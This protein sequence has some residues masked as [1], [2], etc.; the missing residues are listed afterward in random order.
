MRE[1][2]SLSSQIGRLTDGGP[3]RILFPDWEL[4]VRVIGRARLASFKEKDQG[5]GVWLDSWLSE[6][7]DA[8]WKQEIDVVRQF[9]RVRPQSDGS[10]L[11]PL[12]L[13]HV[14][15]HVLIAFSRG[16][17]LILS[18]RSLVTNDGN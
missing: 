9:P 4:L 5:A 3:R 1:V 18:P 17:I 12:P 6:I 11:F 13:G 8:N 15:I 14:G 16:V 10:F 7:R 2:D